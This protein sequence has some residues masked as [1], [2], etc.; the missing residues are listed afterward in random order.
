[1]RQIKFRGKRLDNGEWRVGSLLNIEDTYFI[2]EDDDFSFDY[3]DENTH[4]WFNAQEQE[5]EPNTIGQFTG[6]YDRNGKEIYEGDIIK[7]D[8]LCTVVYD[9]I[10]IA[11]A[12]GVIE[13]HQTGFIFKVFEN[14]INGTGCYFKSDQ[15]TEIEKTVEVIGN[16]HDNPE[17]IKKED[18]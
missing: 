13:W 5:V 15:Q 6:L 4:F 12:I 14:N 17:L 9:I 11:E 18:K 8:I 1:M 16:I 7:H 3:R 10:G 2:I